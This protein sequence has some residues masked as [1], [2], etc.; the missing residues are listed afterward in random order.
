MTT[1]LETVLDQGKA[2]RTLSSQQLLPQRKQW[3]RQNNVWSPFK[4]KNKDIRTTQYIS[5]I[6]D[7]ALVVWRSA[8]PEQV[9]A[10]WLLSCYYKTC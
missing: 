1:R 9:H 2:K 10:D 6:V 7:H 4:V 5:H 8:D 3:K